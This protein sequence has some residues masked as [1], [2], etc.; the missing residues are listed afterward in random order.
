M[1]YK[2]LERLERYHNDD[3]LYDQFSS[4]LFVYGNWKADYYPC[5]V[6]IIDD[7]IGNVM[8]FDIVITKLYDGMVS[9]KFKNWLNV[10][11]NNNC[12]NYINTG[13]I[14]YTYMYGS[15][16]YCDGHDRLYSIND[17]I[18]LCGDCITTVKTS[19]KC[20]RFKTKFPVSLDICAPISS[21]EYQKIYYNIDLTSLNVWRK[22]N[23]IC[24][25]LRLTFSDK[26]SSLKYHQCY[27]F[28]DK[29]STLNVCDTCEQQYMYDPLNYNKC[30]QCAPI[31]TFRNNMIQ[32]FLIEKLLIFSRFNTIS[33]IK[34]R[35]NELLISIIV[36]IF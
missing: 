20:G 11:E 26:L 12:N 13:D 16:L 3:R 17:Y 33:D 5:E 8:I 29:T 27:L 30:P 25:H 18:Y 31:L 9:D 34:F 23:G 28:Y 14:L 35:I 22:Y 32:K 36:T 6:V 1:Y 24:H 7:D 19:N 10:L 2:L 4:R 15:C 21:D